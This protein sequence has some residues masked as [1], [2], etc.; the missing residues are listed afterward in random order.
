[1]RIVRTSF[2]KIQDM[3]EKNITRNGVTVDSFWEDYIL[4]GSHYSI[5]DEDSPVGYFTIHGEN[6]ITSF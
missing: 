2:E 5:H 6:A 3:M 4:E 1:M